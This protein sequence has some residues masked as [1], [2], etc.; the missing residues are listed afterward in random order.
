MDGVKTVIGYSQIFTPAPSGLD[1]FF[2][3]I[4]GT[5]ALRILKYAKSHT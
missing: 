3:H 1:M 4:T 5:K 2:L